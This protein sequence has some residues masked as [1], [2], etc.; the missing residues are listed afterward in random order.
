MR[1]QCSQMSEI[2]RSRVAVVLKPAGPLLICLILLVG[3]PFFPSPPALAGGGARPVRPVE[4]P[5]V[6]PPRIESPDV[7]RGRSGERDYVPPERREQWRR[8]TSLTGPVVSD[9]SPSKT[10]VYLSLKQ[11]TLYFTSNRSDEGFFVD[12]KT[13]EFERY[14]LV[15]LSRE[16]SESLADSP[17]EGQP[18]SAEVVTEDSVFFVDPEIFR[19]LNLDLGRAR[20]VK[21]LA[22][23]HIGNGELASSIDVVPLRNGKV[24]ATIKLADG[25]YARIREP[26]HSRLISK[27][28]AEP[29][30]AGD[31]RILSLVVNSDTQ[32]AIDQ[33][34]LKNNQV[35]APLELGS[36]E[37]RLE[38]VKQL[39][40][41]HAGHLLVVLGHIESDSFVAVND[42]NDELLRV[43]VRTMEQWATSYN[44]RLL[45]LGCNSAKP[46]NGAGVVGKFN[47]LD[48]VAR[49][50]RAISAETVGRFLELFCCAASTTEAPKAVLPLIVSHAL[51]R[52]TSH[53]DGDKDIR[54]TVTVHERTSDQSIVSKS[55]G[56]I[57]LPA[58]R[59][60]YRRPDLDGRN[61]LARRIETSIGGD[62]DDEGDWVG[63][64][65]GACLVGVIVAAI[66]FYH[67]RKR[68][69]LSDHLL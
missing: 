26:N 46:S 4:P 38:G 50:N 69:L 27:L 53:L 54:M 49:L 59:V 47:S 48:A 33:S 57:A 63:V 60:V 25:L 32:A 51:L 58:I 35:K 55:I 41:Q 61:L 37:Q 8:A 16:L 12:R 52:I 9:S 34:K 23:T 68:R 7:E 44:V 1:K 11:G 65:A 43:P 18:Q 14:D 10:R 15:T 31:F 17:R 29:F 21:V 36:A 62:A 13:I 42:R 20:N 28:V 19:E 66:A 64:V 40:A 24:E 6:E 5:R 2:R 56:T 39:F 45:S 3:P 30:R 22:T 67:W